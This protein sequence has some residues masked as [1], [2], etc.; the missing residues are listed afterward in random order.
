M[1][2]ELAFITV[3]S[4]GNKR[5][6]LRPFSCILVNR[7]FGSLGL[8]GTL[9]KAYTAIEF[10]MGMPVTESLHSTKKEANDLIAHTVLN[11]QEK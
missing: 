3:S 4:A 7:N 11:K 5:L 2:R 8:F 6:S 1:Y 10:R 9:T